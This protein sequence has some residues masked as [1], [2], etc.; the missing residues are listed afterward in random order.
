MD[1]N[2]LTRDVVGRSLRT[3]VHLLMDSGSC[4]PW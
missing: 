2:F 1:Q 3:G 4:C